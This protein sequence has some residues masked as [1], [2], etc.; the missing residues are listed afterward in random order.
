MTPRR[1]DDPHPADAIAML[2]VDHQRIRDLFAHYE[3]T[4][5]PKAQWTIAEEVLG[6]LEVH[7]QLEEQ[8]FYPAIADQSD[9]GERLAQG[10]LEEHQIL[11]QLI[12]ELRAMGPQ[13]HGFD[14]QFNVLIQNVEDHVE[15]EEAEL[16]PFAQVTLQDDLGALLAAMQAFKAQILAS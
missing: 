8:V 4:T 15:Y 5:N 12:H 16:F 1:N 9:E 6:E 11:R 10:S 13:I 14:A 2:K 7:A 3:A